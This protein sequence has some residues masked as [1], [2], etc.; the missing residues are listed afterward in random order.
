MQAPATRKST[1][2]RPATTDV[3][4]EAGRRLRDGKLVAFPTETVYGLGADAT[5]GKAVARIYAAKGRPAFNPLIVH[6]ADA[7]DAQAVGVF[8]GPLANLAAAFWPGPLTIVTSRSDACEVS[9]LATAGLE[10]VA[11][12]VP[13]NDTARR[14]IRAAGRPIVA[15]SANRSG[16]VSATTAAHV[17]A[18]LGDADAFVVDGGQTT[19]GIESTIVALAGDQKTELRLLRSGAITAEELSKA[20]GLVVR[21]IA[22]ATDDVTPTAPGQLTSHYAPQARVRL[23]ATYAE[24]G[25][26]LLAFGEPLQPA[27]ADFRNLSERGDLLEAAANLFLHLRELDATG[28]A[29]IAVMPIPETGLGIAI[30]DRLRRAAAPRPA[31][32]AS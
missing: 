13:A 15:P 18:D 12:R 20:S 19:I 3:I 17:V 22:D 26:A 21:D 31:K 7:L 11:I 2:I 14:I 32:S 24:P 5:N 25:E 30:N 29:A 8:D 9:E 27:T 1:I 28:A 23:N 10:T 6:V 16:H 4:A